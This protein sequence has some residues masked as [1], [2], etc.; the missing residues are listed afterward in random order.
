MRKE[1]AK[2][3]SNEIHEIKANFK[4]IYLEQNKDIIKGSEINNNITNT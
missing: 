2:R 3:L 1:T 4:T